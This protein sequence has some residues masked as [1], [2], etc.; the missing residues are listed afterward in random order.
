MCL[1]LKQTLIQILKKHEFKF[2][3]HEFDSGASMIDVWIDNDFYCIQISKDKL[4]W[5]KVV[6][7]SGFDVVPDSGYLNWDE[8]KNEFDKVIERR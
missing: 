3:T 5:S 4:G 8:F 7:N 1:K 2:E 6:E